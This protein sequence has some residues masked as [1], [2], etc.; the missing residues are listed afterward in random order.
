MNGSRT[1]II[2]SSS[3]VFMLCG[4]CQHWKQTMMFKYMGTS[5][6]AEKIKELLFQFLTKC[7]NIGANVVAVICDQ[8]P[9]FDQLA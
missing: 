3:L 1:R 8:G 4:I 2:A 9:N 6:P 7:V 5:C